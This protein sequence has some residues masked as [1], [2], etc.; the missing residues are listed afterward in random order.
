MASSPIIVNAI[1]AVV[2]S[3]KDKGITVFYEHGHPREI[4]NTLSKKSRG[5]AQYEKFPLIAL[6]QDIDEVKTSVT[7]EASLNIIIANSTRPEYKASDRYINNFEPVLYPL[8]MQFEAAIRAS[9]LVTYVDTEYDKIDRLYWGKNGLYGNEGNIFNDYI[10]AI[11]IN[12]L[13]LRFKNIC[14]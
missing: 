13:K 3:M 2:Q 4:V 12:N 6:F 10:D 11:E 1:G 9:K 5:V 8:L 14:T 7:T